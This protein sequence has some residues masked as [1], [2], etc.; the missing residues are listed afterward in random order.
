[1]NEARS[2]LQTIA[3]YL[4]ALLIL[5]WS[6]GPFLWQF[7]TSFQLDKALTSGSPSL[8]PAPFTLEHYYN[9]FIEKQLHRY[10]WNSLVVSLATTFLCLFVGSLAAFALSRLN[11]KGR[12]GILMVIL[13]VSMF[14]Q[15]ALVGPLYLVATNLGLLDTYTALIITYL[16]LGLPLVT[17]VLFGYFET[18]PREI[19]EAARMDGVS[20]PGLLWHI[21]LPMSLP[22]LVTTGLLAF[23]TAWNEFLFALAFTSNID[24]QTIPVGIANFT[25]LY[26]VPWGDIAAASAVVTVPLIVLVLFFQR[27]IIEGL[28]QGGIKE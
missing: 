8:I 11:V 28:T 20:V 10:V 7:S 9:A 5:V 26:Y 3:I 24:R 16:A 23:I 19:D 6:G 17:W 25:N 15:I 2:P 21:I 13:S 1:M 12:F 27:H 18:L 22:S 4:G 14:P